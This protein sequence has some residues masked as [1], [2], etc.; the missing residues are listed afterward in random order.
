MRP[1]N[2]LQAALFVCV[3]K[4]KLIAG[5]SF[6]NELLNTMWCSV[7]IAIAVNESLLMYKKRPVNML[8][9]ASNILF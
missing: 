6:D 7:S 8:Q 3:L 2:V 4:Q 9:A 1:V 5:R